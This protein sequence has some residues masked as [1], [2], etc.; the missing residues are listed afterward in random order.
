MKLRIF[1]LTFLLIALGVFLQGCKGEEEEEKE[2][3]DLVEPD[4]AI[5]TPGHDEKFTVGDEIK[6]KIE[7]NH[8]DL[9]SDLQLYVDDTLYKDSLLLEDQ[10]LKVSTQNA[11]VGF[12]PIYLKYKD[13]KGE[14]HRDN[15]TITLF[16]DI[17][18][19]YWETN[20]IN[21]YPHD[22][23][24]YTQ[25]LEFYKGRLYESTGQ[26]GTSLVAEVEL[27]SGQHLRKVDLDDAFFGEGITILNDQLY[28]LTYRAGKCFVYDINTLDIVNE[29]T[30]QDEG[31]GLCNNGSSLIMSNGSSD[32]VWRDPT[33][34]EVTKTLQVF[35]NQSNLT[36]INELELI[37]GDLYANIYTDTRVARIDT[38]TGK[39]KTYINLAPLVNAQPPGS[40][41]LNGIAAWNGK[42]YVTGKLWHYLYEVKF[43]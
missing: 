13:G 12:V 34:F 24:S 33:T 20:M 36:Q 30:Y 1:L 5:I 2:K 29:F 3:E 10:E 28:Q 22:P 42:I 40:E 41:V 4:V 35:D 18:P 6:V 14:E 26:Y 16:S 31:W 17:I 39:V 43:Q 32:I 8:P 21:A 9:I 37:D 38:T 15:R 23:K 25:G 7:V 19:E 11:R 27:T